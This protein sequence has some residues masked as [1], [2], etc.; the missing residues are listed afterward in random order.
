[1]ECIRE[2]LLHIIE[3]CESLGANCLN[4]FGDFVIAD[5]EMCRF[6]N[7]LLLHVLLLHVLVLA[8]LAVEFF[9]SH[10]VVFGDSLLFQKSASGLNTT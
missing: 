10:L 3:V 8:L 6:L 4:G 7:G 1:M 5:N 2:C 9:A